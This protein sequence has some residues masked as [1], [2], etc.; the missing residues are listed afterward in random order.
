VG[1]EGE[2]YTQLDPDGHKNRD[3][4]R[5]FSKA[6]DTPFANAFPAAVDLKKIHR[7]RFPSR[8]NIS[9]RNDLKRI[10]Y[11]ISEYDEHIPL[12]DLTREAIANY[13][14]ALLVR[15][16]HYISKLI[17]WH[18]INNE[19]LHFPVDP[20]VH[21]GI[22]L[23]NM[24]YLYDVYR[25]A[26]NCACINLMI[27]DCNRE[28][29]FSD[30]GITA[31]EPWSK[32]TIPFEIYVPLTPKLS[33]NVLPLPN[34]YTKG[35]WVTRVNTRGVARYNRIMLSE[36][37]R[38]VFS[39]SA[40]PLAFIQKHFGMPAPSPFGSRLV[41]GRLETIYNPSRDRP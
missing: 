41:N 7:N 3:I 21:R 23:Q 35:L 2:L 38:F 19:N 29:I 16:P 1:V 28:F 32:R 18:Q 22:A 31:Q 5:W 17:S 37:K 39:R 6:I 12:P 33:L 24:I 8:G 25:E 34:A 9:Q 13:I 27:A 10:G 30:G 36:A 15:S 20:Q 11:I 26:I 14:A 4:E 40:P